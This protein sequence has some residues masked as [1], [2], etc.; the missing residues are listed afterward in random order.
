MF[1]LA[2]GMILISDYFKE[3][4]ILFLK[5]KEY[6]IKTQGLGQMKVVLTNGR[7]SAEK[8]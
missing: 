1:R 4:W 6:E 2:L 5:V 8:I 7:R 3:Y